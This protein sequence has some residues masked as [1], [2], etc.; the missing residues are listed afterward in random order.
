M[1][2]RSCESVTLIRGRQAISATWYLPTKRPTAD[3]P[4]SPRERTDQGTRIPPHGRPRSGGLHR[5]EPGSARHEN[6]ELLHIARKCAADVGDAG[7]A[8]TGF[9]MFYALLLAEMSTA[10]RVLHPCRG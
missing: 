6:P 1:S 4:A 5:G 7:R 10:E 2:A 8:M 9:G 3:E